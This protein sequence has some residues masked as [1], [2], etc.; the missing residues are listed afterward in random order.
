MEN[1]KKQKT[2]IIEF[3]TLRFLKYI[4]IG[5]SLLYIGTCDLIKAIYINHVIFY[6]VLTRHV[7]ILDSNVMVYR[8]NYK[9]NFGS[10]L[11]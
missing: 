9:V 4:L 5:D 6:R 7:V 8:G 11:F 2:L 1:G 3:L 10:K